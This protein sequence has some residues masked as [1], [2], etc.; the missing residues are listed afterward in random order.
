VQ[1]RTRCA[2]LFRIDTLVSIFVPLVVLLPFG[3]PVLTAAKQN[4]Q[5]ALPKDLC[6]SFLRDGDVWTLCGGKQEHLPLNGR[7]WHYAVSSDGSSFAFITEEPSSTRGGIAHKKL[8]VVSLK[9]EHKTE[10]KETSL[11]FLSA[12]CGA[13]VGYQAGTRETR[14]VTSG[15][16]LSISSRQ[17]IKCDSSRRTIVGWDDL[18]AKSAT[19]TVQV[20]ETEAEKVPASTTGGHNFGVSPS[21]EY[22]AFFSEKS[23][24]DQLCIQRVGSAAQCA[25]GIDVVGF[26]GIS[27]SDSGAALFT[28]H[29][30]KG[31]FYKDMGHFS[32]K[33]RAGYSSEDECVAVYY[34]QVDRSAPALI[35]G[36][37][38]YSQW[39]SPEAAERLRDWANTLP[40]AHQPPISK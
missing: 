21:G 38:R 29:T 17:F 2:P 24:S 31:C 37:A 28:G 36:L 10:V 27:L 4:A 14:D 15:Q 23:G 40:A 1:P 39:I 11:D 22:I 32:E 25:G 13:I 34:W 16:L 8:Q 26:D 19:L 33:P 35:E 3:M 5:A 7:V 9:S 30:G 12:S 6:Y 20:N 18:N